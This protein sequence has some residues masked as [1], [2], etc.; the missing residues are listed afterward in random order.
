V[1]VLAGVMPGLV[2]ALAVGLLLRG[3]HLLRTDPD[4]GLN[5]EEVLY[6]N[7]SARDRAGSQ[8]ALT[9]LSY[10]LVP[11]LRR[12]LSR[13]ATRWL[14]QQVDMAGR[15]QGL[16]V[17]AVLAKFVL[18]GL[19]VGPIFVYG[20]FTGNLL[21]VVL[22][23]AI[24]VVLPLAQLSG[25]ARRR[26]EAIDRDLPDF[27]DV[28]AVTVSAG[29]GFRAALL[30]V[31]G[32]FGGAI[33]EEINTVL[34]QITNGASVRSAFS[35]MRDRTRSD[36]VNEFVTAYLQAEELGA[37]L[38]DTLNQ[39]AADMRRA[40]AQRMRQHAS[41][42]EPRISLVMTTVLIPGAIVILVGGMFL[43]LDAGQLGGVLGG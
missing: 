18:W 33:S 31:A 28:L 29:L 11:R 21:F 32:R 15:P 42:I 25:L 5:A 23:V 13:Q 2:A 24:I 1:T 14:Q 3:Y 43:A 40:N 27:L 7:K 38:A 12:V 34:H 41:K 30:T 19:M 35:A 16:D 36:A 9:A 37:P 10:R 20:V 6:L 26:R 4:V 8:S 39:I 22:P 17:D